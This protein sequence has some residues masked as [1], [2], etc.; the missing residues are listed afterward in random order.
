MTLT[1]PKRTFTV[2]EYLALTQNHAVFSP[3]ERLELI[4]GEIFIMTPA[5]SPHASAVTKLSVGFAR[6]YGDR[7][8]VWSQNP[9]K[10]SGSMPEPDV[11]LLKLS[12]DVYDSSYPVA[13][14]A[15]LLVEVSQTSLAYDRGIKLPLYASHL[16]PEVWIVNLEQRQLEVYREPRPGTYKT[17]FVLTFEEPLSP[18]AFP[19]EAEAWLSR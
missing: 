2:E 11:A 17:S 7:A 3:D 19:N 1:A 14:D 15:L 8:V 4:Q 6:R 5:G 13:E 10:L 9:L 16:I 18:L 12:A